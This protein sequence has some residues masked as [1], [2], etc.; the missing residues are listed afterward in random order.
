[1]PG[2]YR[3]KLLV[4]CDKLLDSLLKLLFFP[5][6]TKREF[7]TRG[8]FHWPKKSGNFILMDYFV[9]RG[10]NVFHLTQVPF[11]LSSKW[12]D[13]NKDSGYNPHQSFNFDGD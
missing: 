6:E 7:D 8:I 11:I 2:V 13:L 10:K 9:Y 12:Q 5:L 1:M 3:K 4:T